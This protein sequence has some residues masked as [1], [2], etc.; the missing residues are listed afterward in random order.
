MPA[1]FRVADPASKEPEAVM[2]CPRLTFNCFCVFRRSTSTVSSLD[3]G[4]QG[5]SP[6]NRVTNTVMDMTCT[7]TVPLCDSKLS[8]TPSVKSSSSSHCLFRCWRYYLSL[9]IIIM[10]LAMFQGALHL[11]SIRFGGL[12]WGN[13]SQQSFQGNELSHPAAHPRCFTPQGAASR[14]LAAWHRKTP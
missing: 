13:V 14:P 2:R 6:L 4:T 9:S 3:A 5:W 8:S 11:C 12:G 1:C 7:G 10:T